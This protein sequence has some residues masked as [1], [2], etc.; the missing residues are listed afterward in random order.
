MKSKVVIDSNV[1]VAAR[2]S[3]TGASHRLVE[4]YF[5]QP[6]SWDWMI[7]T[8][9][10]LEYEEQ[11]GHLGVTKADIGAFLD[12]L[13]ANA[14]QVRITF[15]LRPFLHDPDDDFIAELAV[16]ASADVI[17]TF[18]TRNFRMARLLG[19]RVETP[20]EFLDSGTR[21]ERHH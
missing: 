15:R 1:L 17:V 11:L 14:T 2:K 19:I 12:D 3:R 13:A 20:A 21:H 4:D 18:N 5:C 10:L 8:A 6:G 9:A 16:A 7:S